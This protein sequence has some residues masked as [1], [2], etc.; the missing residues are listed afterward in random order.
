MC[1]PDVYEIDMPTASI[2]AITSKITNSLNFTCQ[3]YT[4]LFLKF[5][6]FFIS[7]LFTFSA[8]FL[9]LYDYIRCKITPISAAGNNK[10][11]TYRFFLH[12]F[13]FYIF[14][15]CHD[16]CRFFILHTT[17]SYFNFA[18]IPFKYSHVL[19]VE[20]ISSFSLKE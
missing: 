3:V 12:M 13:Y 8:H 1:F 5:Q 20:A 6:F 17:L 4:C 14:S 16:V 15:N 11:R 2:S 7:V 18:R 19:C 10:N 9:L